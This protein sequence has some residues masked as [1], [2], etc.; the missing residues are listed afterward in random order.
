[1]IAKIEAAQRPLRVRELADFAALYG[2]EVQ[3]LIYPPSSSLRE[4]T[5]ELREAEVRRNL[6][7]QQ[8]MAATAR[9]SELR[10]E[11][12]A[13]EGEL[14]S[15]QRMLVMLDERAD[16]LRQEMK[17]FAARPDLSDARTAAEFLEKLRQF[18][19]GAGNPSHHEIAIHAGNKMSASVIA[20]GALRRQYP[21]SA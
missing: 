8:A 5:Q 7:R 16:F 17:K 14:E 9:A 11:L 3:Q 20:A 12:I 2:A 15:V 18:K 19:A 4:V 6:Y 21:A 10:A 1:M 13:A